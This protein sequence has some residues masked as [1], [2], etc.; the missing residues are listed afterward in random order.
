MRKAIVTIVVALLLVGGGWYW[1]SP[2]YTLS[3]MKTAA[4]AGDSDKLA[5]YID[6]PALR[7]SMKEELKAQAAAE[8]LKQKDGGF[9]A[10]GAMLAVN[11]VDG[12]VDGMV[13]PTTMRK[14]FLADKAK[15]PEGITKVDATRNDMVME[16]VGLSEF[17]LHPSGKDADSGLIFYRN[18]LSWKL[19]AMRLPS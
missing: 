3:Q 10:F 12:M 17:R 13:N 16:R 6:F 8:M 9:A 5:S 11:M 7:T 18:G 19:A 1:Y 2:H 4:E 14:V 15:G